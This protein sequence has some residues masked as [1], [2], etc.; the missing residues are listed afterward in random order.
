MRPLETPD[1]ARE[2]LENIAFFPES[3][4]D[5]RTQAALAVE[6]VLDGIMKALVAGRQV[7]LRNRFT[8]TPTIRKA[9]KDLVLGSLP[10]VP[11]VQVHFKSSTCL[12][13]LFKDSEFL[14][15]ANREGFSHLDPEP[16]RFERS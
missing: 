8:L 10:S 3:D 6:V 11:T 14:A 7:K 16:D 9:R 12:K 2:V 5:Y 4:E 13:D 15:L 1:L